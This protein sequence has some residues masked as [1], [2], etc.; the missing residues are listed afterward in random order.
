MDWNA[1]ILF[2]VLASSLVASAVIFLL[3][4]S[5]H[6][7]R[8]AFN[9]AAAVLKLVLVVWIIWGVYRNIDYELRFT[10]IDGV[11]FILRAD[12]LALLFAGLSAV[13]W[14]FTTIYAV[15]YLEDSPNRSRFFGFFSLC[16]AS[17]FGIALAGNLFT[18]FMFYEML[19]LATYPLV[20]HRGTPESLRAGRQYL[21]Y[22]LSGGVVLLVGIA[23]LH[24]IAGDLPFREGGHC[25][26]RRRGDEQQS[27]HASFC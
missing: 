20:V 10:I 16:V 9:L 4:E 3:A 25:P 12:A 24:G 5:R 8:T 6:A 14:L 22:T 19:T 1:L 18:L 15:G 13:L 11:D 27:R 26:G 2:G 17:T 7:T 21:A 23:W